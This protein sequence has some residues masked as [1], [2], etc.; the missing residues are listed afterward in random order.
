MDKSTKKLLNGSMVYF[1]GNALTQLVSLLLMRFVTG[2]ITPDEYGFF[3]LVTTISN[4]A[5]PFVTLQVADATFKFVLKSR[6]DDE[7]KSYFTVCFAVTF[8]SSVVI[9]ASVFICSSFIAIPNTLLVAIY[10][11]SYSLFGIYQ[12]LIRCLNKSKVFVTGNL[13]KTVLFISLEILLI[14]TLNMGI[15]ALLLAH[16]LSLAFFL[17]YAELRVRALKFLDFRTLRASTFKQMFRFSIPLIPNA[18]FWWLTS[19]VNHVI[20]T[21]K[22]GMDVNGI[23]SVSGKFTSVLVMVTSVLNMSWQDTAIADYGSK[24]FSVFLTKTFNTFVKLIFS[25]IAVI[26]PF[27]AV[28]IPHM[29]DPT[30]YA[31]IPYT[32]FL[33]LVSGFSAMSGFVAQIYTGKGKTSNI[34][35][36]SIFGMVANVS[37]VALL[38]GKVGLWAAVFGSLSADVVLFSLRTFF[39]RK[40]FAKGIEF[41]KFLII[42]LM[43]TVSF[44]LYLNEGT[45]PNLIWFFVAA[46]F[47]ILLNF[48]F[49]RNIWSLTIGRMR[50]TKNKSEEYAA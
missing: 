18:A 11:A 46:V 27:I 10:M 50:K 13:I 35:I 41:G 7:K 32:P 3:N 9:I 44:Y 45:V 23:Y 31:S 12:K 25:A 36:T 42:V 49:A 2:N 34:F 4:L 8:I 1:V 33:M 5:I 17:V 24:D 28:V 26:I 19:S 29:I 6:C 43:S 21:A 20:V 16:T 22:L 40:E 30:Y 15:E 37:V 39:A 38:I 48:D 14:S 47:A